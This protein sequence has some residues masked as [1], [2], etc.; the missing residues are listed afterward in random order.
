MIRLI[1]SVR[2]SAAE[3]YGQPIYVPSRGVALR[4]FADEVN[5]AAMDNPL[6]QHPDDFILYELGSFD[7]STGLF[8]CHEPQQLARGKDVLLKTSP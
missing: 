2:D 3:L 1:C 8:V 4:S 7:E 6:H 5:R